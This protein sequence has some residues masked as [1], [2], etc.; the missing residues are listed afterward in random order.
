VNRLAKGTSH[1]IIMHLRATNFY[2]GPEK[3]IIEHLKRLNKG[4]YTGIL[5]SFIEKESPNETLERAKAEGI[6]HHGIPMSGPLDFS[7]LWRLGRLL[8]RERV[9]LLCTH[10]Y[11]S[12]VMGWS[13]GGMLE[14][15]VVS[16]S[17][18]DTAENS[19]VS[20][21]EWLERRTLSRLAGII[22]VSEGQRKRLK[23]YG[24][25]NEKSWVVHNAVSVLPHINGEA[26]ALIRGT[27]RERLG[28]PGEAVMV[29]YAGRLSPEKGARFL[30][31]A[32]SKIG[33]KVGGAY[34]V[35]CGNGVCKENLEKQARHL[36]VA[37]R[38]RFMG[39][40]RDIG[41]IFQ[42]M[43]LLVLPSLTEGLPNVV[44]EAF[45]YAKPVVGTS[46]GG[47]PEVVEDGT[48][49]FLVPPGRPDLLAE[50]ITRCL[51]IPD[52]MRKMGEAGYRTVKSR[53]SFEE[54]TTR[55]ESIYHRLLNNVDD[56]CPHD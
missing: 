3:Q 48:N 44:L 16:F 49:G 10:G 4:R 56:E 12:T 35:F 45:A 5:V 26:D 18:G 37:D 42:A 11:N 2:G 31:D 52:T 27:V 39:F 38:C 24:I 55:L 20:I 25:V 36:D 17:R 23:S 7:A 9:D 41:E 15:P 54:Q 30:V 1:K 28:L 53:F 40:R 19:K 46:V 47:V 32:V 6:R 22:C 34:F 50:A 8:H 14:I 43:D 51:T 13:A 33:E 21:Y 29:V